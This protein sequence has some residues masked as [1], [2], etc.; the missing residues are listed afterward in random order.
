LVLAVLASACS[1]SSSTPSGSSSTPASTAG[2]S[3]GTLEKTTLN[4]GALPVAD[5]A[6]LYLAIKNGYFK[7]VGLTVNAVPVAQ[8]TQAIPDML[9]GT[10]DIIAGANYVSYFLAQSK[11]ALS[12][13]VLVEATACK[14]NTF[15]VYTLPSSKITTPAQLAGKS[16]AVNINPNVQT[17]TI[18][19]ILKADSLSPT[20]VHYVVIPFPEMVAALKAHRV[21]AIA[22]IEPFITAAKQ[23]LGAVS[24]L[25]ECQGVTSGFPLSGYFALSSWTTKYPNTAHAFEKAMAKAQALANSDPAAVRSILP[26]YTTIKP[27]VA[28]AVSLNVYP[29]TLTT[30]PLQQVASLML[31]Q[32]M[33]KSPLDVTNL[34]GP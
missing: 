31:A 19:A 15:G 13:K 20:S 18:G 30:A 24:A 10:V 26:T 32:G 23:S 9:H 3:G 25:S 33:L 6:A 5:D 34:L 8:S 27:A 4:V 21:D 16:I 14:T 22:A 29:S 11:G 28:N 12:F 1:S 2:S 7:Q 17:L